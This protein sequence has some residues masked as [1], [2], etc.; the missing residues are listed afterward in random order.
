MQ[1]LLVRH[2]ESVGNVAQ[3]MQ[4]SD[5]PL[6]DNGRRQAHAIARA[7]AERGNIRR[8]YASPLARALE[9]AQTIGAALEI[10]PE[11]RP[12]LAE[13]NIGRA[14]GYSLKEWI[15]KYPEDSAGFHVNGVD[16]VFPDGESGRQLG[17]RVAAELDQIIAAH[18]GEEGATVVVSHGGALAWGLAYLLGE[19]SESWPRHAFDNCSLT[20]I[21]VP[22]TVDQPYTVVRHNDIAHLEPEPTEEAATG[23]L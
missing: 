10:A 5:D 2:G 3:V 12:G 23:R 9:T 17:T 8:I 7:L 6:T 20:E 21:M 18:R 1:L 16:Y 15:A 22:D 4:G 11:L 13:I 19:V 14:A